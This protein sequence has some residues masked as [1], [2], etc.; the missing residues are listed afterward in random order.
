V[1]TLFNSKP[2]P[3]FKNTEYYDFIHGWHTCY[4]SPIQCRIPDIED[5]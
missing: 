5:L 4:S 1:N 2:V 3:P